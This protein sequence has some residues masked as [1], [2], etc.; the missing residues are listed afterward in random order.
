V[1]RVDEY[2]MLEDVGEIAG[3]IGVA[4]GEHFLIP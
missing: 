3:V 1:Q 4:V 2:Q